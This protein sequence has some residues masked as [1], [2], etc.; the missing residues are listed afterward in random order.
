[1]MQ[2]SLALLTVPFVL[3]VLP[4]QNVGLTFDPTVDGFVEVPYSP[5]T[6]PLSGITV[7]AWMTYDDSTTQTGYRYPTIIRQG[8][9]PGGENIMLRV[10][11]DN[12][13][14]LELRWRVKTTTGA[15]ITTNY[16]FQPGEFL[17]WTHVAGTYDGVDLK[18]F[19]NGLEVGVAAGNGEPIRDVNDVFRIGK[20][21]DV[22]TPIEVWNGELDEVR[23]WPFARTAE[24]IQQTMMLELDSVPGYVSTWN[25][26]N[27]YDD[28][29]GGQNATS[30]GTVAFTANPLVLTPAPLFFGIQVGASTPGCLGDIKLVTSG[31]SVAN[32]NDFRVVATRLPP[33]APAFWGAS[34]GT[35]PVG[36]PLL[37][38]DVWLDPTGLVVAGVVADV[39]GSCSVGL[40]IPASGVGITLGVQC[41][42]LDVCGP[43][44]FTAS[45]ALVIAVQ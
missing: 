28:S 37:G 39:L 10:D 45:D 26:N 42:A 22:A 40:P 23:L 15:T 2:R 16:L 6:L 31:P 18:L 1:M 44:G 25:F 5:Q 13:N 33:A 20:G 21:S 14:Q 27:N 41:I 36:L 3:A 9:G 29:S 34:V 12:T 7:E 38:V 19:V 11:A 24:D 4:A 43:Q 32:Y 8:I 35:L 17:N 30:G